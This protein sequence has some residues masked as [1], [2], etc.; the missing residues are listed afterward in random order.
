M[1]VEYVSK[2]KL[3]GRIIR[4]DIDPGYQEGREKGRGSNGLQR[5]DD[6]RNKED[7]Q[8]PKKGKD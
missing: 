5:R 8:R 1:A 4:V 6:F 7:P 3:G 2:V